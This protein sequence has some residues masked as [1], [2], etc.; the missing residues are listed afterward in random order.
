MLFWGVE[1]AMAFKHPLKILLD[2]ALFPVHP[3]LMV[4]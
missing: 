3:Q 1:D 2:V 4:L